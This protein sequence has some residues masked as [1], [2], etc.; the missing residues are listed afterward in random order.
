MGKGSNPLAPMNKL[1]GEINP[2][3]KKTNEVVHSYTGIDPTREDEGLKKKQEPPT[4]NWGNNG[5]S[6]RTVATTSSQGKIKKVYDKKD[7]KR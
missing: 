6:S 2:V 1:V 5:T 3:A 7:E 4:I